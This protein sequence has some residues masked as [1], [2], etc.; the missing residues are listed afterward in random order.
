[1]KNLSQL[2]IAIFA[3]SLSA[4]LPAQTNKALDFAEQDRVDI[5]NYE[6]V[7]FTGLTVEAW[8]KLD[9]YLDKW[10]FNSTGS[11]VIM[12]KTNPSI[13][14]HNDYGII[15]MVLCLNHYQSHDKQL[16]FGLNFGEDGDKHIGLH[17]GDTVRLNE[18]HHLAGTWDGAFMHVYIDGVLANSIDVVDSIGN[19][20]FYS[21]DYG[22]YMGYRDEGQYGYL[23]G[24]I[25]EVRIWN[26]ARTES[27]LRETMY[28]QVTGSEPG[29]H[30]YWNLNE[31]TG[32]LVF[33]QGPNEFDGFLGSN[34]GTGSDYR[35][36]NWVTSAAPVPY[37]TT[38]DGYWSSDGIWAS[39]QLAPINDWAQVNIKNEVTLGADETIKDLTIANTGALTIDNSYTLTMDGEILIES[40][41]TGTGSII[42]KGSLV[43]TSA[44]VERFLSQDRWHYVS[45]PVE[46]PTA[47]VFTSIYLRSWDEPTETWSYITNVNTGLNE[48]EG[49]AA[50]ASSAYTGDATV[51]FSGTL[52]TGNYA[53]A[54]T[55]TSGTTAPPGEDPSGYN[56]IG[57]PYPSGI[58][59]DGAGW[60]RSNVDDAIY[61]ITYVGGERQYAS[62]ID[63]VGTHG[64]T[65][66]IAP[67]QGFYVKCNNTAGGNIQVSNAARIHTN[68]PF[69]KNSTE[70]A[71]LIKLRVED[72][73]GF[74]DET[75]IRAKDGASLGFDGSMDAYKMMGGEGIPQLYTAFDP[76]TLYSINT[77]DEI[78]ANTVIPVLFEPGI[79]G[80]YELS[81]KMKEG[82][83]T[84]KL[85]LEDKKEGTM[86][87]LKDFGVYKF[88]GTVNDD[89]NRFMLRFSANDVELPQ[90]GTGTDALVYTSE[91]GIMVNLQTAEK[92]QALIYDL[93]GRKV[94]SG[95]IRQGNNAIHLD[96]KS[97][98]FLVKITTSENI[99]TQ[100]VFI[101]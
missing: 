17:S 37:Y 16:A 98:Y 33:D 45:V 4:H 71:Q 83:E 62:Y 23:D 52:N 63:G 60:T 29:I 56:F 57:N 40:D 59:W 31:G 80:L 91:N 87:N 9:S 93:S 1:M 99:Y 34:N 15:L 18:W 97:G 55:H 49:Y 74:F 82:L 64:A 36:P 84:L 47:G 73:N 90:A 77:L 72:K 6:M 28:Q 53:M 86:I 21:P 101:K 25:D 2:F 43:Y 19:E 44:E 96:T 89:P 100:N 75:I 46:N 88:I 48:M 12:Q 66:E 94:F 61:I 58:D 69:F 51:L 81:F 95:D 7:D 85:Y 76:E 24:T 50:W 78:N 38:Q 32:Q 54:L 5:Q 68:Q 65:S 22:L 26:Y 14:S 41:A 8:I 13:T 10:Y 79:D 27:Q 92:G 20:P 11:P 3:L 39:G 35:E 30:A 42:D 67:H 70:A